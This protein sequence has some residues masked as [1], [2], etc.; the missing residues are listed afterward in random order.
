MF[1]CL[2]DYFI[3]WLDFWSQTVIISA[4]LEAEEPQS[5]AS[6][7]LL[8][9][10]QGEEYFENL[11][12]DPLRRGAFNGEAPAGGL[13][14]GPPYRW[15]WA[16]CWRGRK[17]PVKRWLGVPPAALEVRPA[18]NG[19]GEGRVLGSMASGGRS[20][21]VAVERPTRNGNGQEAAYS[22]YFRDGQAVGRD[23]GRPA[24][25]VTEVR[26]RVRTRRSAGRGIR[27]GDPT[28]EDPLPVVRKEMDG[29]WAAC[30]VD[31]SSKGNAPLKASLLRGSSFTKNGGQT[32]VWDALS[33]TWPVCRMPRREYFSWRGIKLAPGPEQ[34]LYPTWAGGEG[35][36]MLRKK[37]E[38]DK[39][40][41]PPCSN[42]IAGWG[43]DIGAGSC[44]GASKGLCP[45]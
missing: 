25:E 2:L 42:Y 40:N 44:G 43:K 11:A 7:L 4:R 21:Q 20:P 12:K 33:Q 36:K 39:F 15:G 45:K 23:W 17:G 14:G 8:P 27:G 28:G 18:P 34:G 6:R 41:P 29:W 10:R 16:T 22:R 35:N 24:V 26:R 1:F 30:P 31:A 9:R 32:T 19:Q 38:V 13:G 37:D 3:A 5:P